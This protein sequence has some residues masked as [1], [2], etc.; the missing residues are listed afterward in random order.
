MNKNQMQYEYIPLY[1]R[2]KC[3]FLQRSVAFGKKNVI[4]MWIPNFNNT[5]AKSL[6]PQSTIK[7]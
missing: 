2:E 4:S 1:S 3:L 6:K 5:P 7:L